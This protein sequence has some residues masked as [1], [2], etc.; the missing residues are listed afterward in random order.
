MYSQL[1]DIELVR[2]EDDDDDANGSHGIRI[3]EFTL[4]VLNEPLARKLGAKCSIVRSG[5]T[6][7][8]ERHLLRVDA[9]DFAADYHDIDAVQCINATVHLKYTNESGV[10]HNQCHSVRIHLEIRLVQAVRLTIDNIVDLKYVSSLLGIGD[11]VAA[12]LI[13]SIIST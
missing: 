6:I 12:V 11:F 4:T 1:F 13:I 5:D 7:E 8:L 9:S 3:V 10:Q 2:R